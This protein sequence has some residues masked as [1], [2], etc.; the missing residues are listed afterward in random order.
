MGFYLA[1]LL[2]SR[3]TYAGSSRPVM[4]SRS[5]YWIMVE[6]TYLGLRTSSPLM[7]IRRFILKRF[8]TSDFVIHYFELEMIFLERIRL[9][10]SETTVMSYSKSSWNL[11]SI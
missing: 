10:I 11:P 3:T 6:M 1:G 7:S 5:S 8:G 2:L 9:V 4:F